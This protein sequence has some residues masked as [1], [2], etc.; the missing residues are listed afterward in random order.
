[1]VLS[2]V[3]VA[4]LLAISYLLVSFFSSNYLNAEAGS[5]TRGKHSQQKIQRIATADPGILIGCLVD[6]LLEDGIHLLMEAE[7]LLCDCR[8][9]LYRTFRC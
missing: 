4:S 6:I 3:V 1:M 7:A 9:A 8:V 5:E 2:S